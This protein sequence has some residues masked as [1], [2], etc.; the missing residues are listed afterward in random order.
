MGSRRKNWRKGGLPLLL[1]SEADVRAF[2]ELLAD[3]VCS[4][5]KQKY[6]DHWDADHFFE[7][8]EDFDPDEA[9]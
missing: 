5:C 6:R 4:R 7:Y 8:A 9:D 3:F 1:F 2:R